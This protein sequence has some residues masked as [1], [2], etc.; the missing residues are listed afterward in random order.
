MSLALVRPDL[1]YAWSGPSLLVVNT[2][3]ECSEDQRVSG[4]YFRETRF[5]R[6]LQL[7]VNGHPPWPCEVAS[8]SPDRLAFTYVHPEISEP[9]GGGTGQAGDEEKIDSDGISERALDIR[10]TYTVHAGWLDVH[11]AMA[12]RARQAV[13]LKVAWAVGADFTDIQEAEA[14]R[15][16]DHHLGFRTRIDPEG[17]L[18]Q[19]IDL[20]PQ[21]VREHAFRVWPSGTSAD[22]SADEVRVRHATLERWRASF[23][24][25]EVPGN[26][27]AERIVASNVRDFGSFPL[28]DGDPDEWLALQAGMP[29]YPA[30]FGRDAVTAGWQ[31]GMVDQ[32][33][34]LSAALVRLGRMQSSRFDDWRDE[35][36]GRIPYQMRTGPLAVLN[37]NP[38]AAYYADFASPLMYVIA[39]ANLYAWVGDKHVVRRH[40][41]TARRILDWARDYGDRDHD[42]YL[43]YLTR[44]AKGT[45]NQGWKDSGDAIIYD[46]G[47]PVP[48]PIAT[49]ELQGYWYVA[50]VVTAAMAWMIGER[51]LAR[52]YWRSAA[53]LKMR[54]NRDWWIEPEGFFALAL[55]PEKRPVRAVTSNVG[56][57]LATGIVASDHLRPVVDRLFAPDMFS[58]WGIRTLSSA[59]RYYNPLSY[60]RG[61]VW[62]VEQ[63][64]ILFG[65]RR[66]GFHAQAHDLALALFDL[67]QLYPEYRIP[68]CVGGYAKSESAT[69]GAYPRANTPQ[70][71]NATAFPLTVQ[72]LLGLLPLA[73]FETLVV[74][75]SLPSWMPDVIVR[76]LRVGHARVTLRCWRNAHGV[77]RFK[78]LHRVGTLHVVRQPPPEAI[79]AGLT[80]RAGALGETVLRAVR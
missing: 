62:A 41:D 36:P 29:L 37:A 70:L 44:S 34:T 27:I 12:N 49:C 35:E 6:T 13:H 45:K 74:D 77:C 24:G 31:A 46:D 17:A 43:E 71:W 57:C 69:P 16:K 54:F 5:L 52:D 26:R 20:L 9:S 4:Y 28:L 22:L 73:P 79:D 63:A 8:P 33:Q 42:G 66:F 7:R 53:E 50:Q 68:E 56:H 67:A 78:V 76:D 25:I 1:L 59:H 38:Y 51:T 32:G 2:R 15:P 10:I 3:G 65:L 39:L 14:S 40:W 21:Q 75:P 55:D 19:E 64:T 30:F 23:A 58:G 11:A 60:H 48:A 18:E 47:S 61:T 80:E 72:V